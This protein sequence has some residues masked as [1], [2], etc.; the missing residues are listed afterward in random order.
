MR[1]EAVDINCL[2][3]WTTLSALATET[4]TLKLGNMVTCQSYRNPALHVNIAA[5]LDHISE[6][7]VYFGIGAGWK[8]VEYKAYDMQ[9]TKPRVRL[10]QLEEAIEIATRM[11]A[12][13]RAR[14]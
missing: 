4:T 14:G 3:C 13:N 7:R 11:R 5:S 6:G 10:N 9:F 2:E 8:E 1:A 12:R